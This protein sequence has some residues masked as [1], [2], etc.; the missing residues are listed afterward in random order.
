M[1]PNIA[2]L[3]ARLDSERL[4]QKHFKKI[5]NGV[6]ID[7]CLN[8]LKKGTDYTI[9]LATSNR[10]LDKPLIDWAAENQIESFAGD[11]FD[12]KKRIKDCVQ[13]FN[14]SYFARV[15]ADSP[16]LN[17]KLISDGFSFLNE[18]SPFLKTLC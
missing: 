5:G 12:I 3:L 10:E 11:A 13:H 6:L 4:P 14:A 7:H 2:I 15:N 9:V 18:H 8:G 17:A 1:S 16:F